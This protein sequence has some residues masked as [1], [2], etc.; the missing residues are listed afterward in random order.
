MRSAHSAVEVA[1]YLLWRVAQEQP[2]EPAFLTPM[3]LQKLLYYVQGWHMVET[4]SP[5]F[6]DEIRAWRDGPVVGAVYHEFREWR[7]NPITEHPEE[8]PALTE[9]TRGLVE[10]VWIRYRDYSGFKLSDMTHDEMPWRKARGA[11][12]R[13]VK[14]DTLMPLSD[15]EQE[16]REQSERAE[17][18]LRAHARQ[19]RQAARDQTRRVAPWVYERKSPGA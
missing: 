19:I 2:E 15:I 16:F 9:E 17:A 13:N 18:R 10:S 8:P 6:G 5:A 11:L 7:K 14:S 1:R 12:P 3:Q 4:G